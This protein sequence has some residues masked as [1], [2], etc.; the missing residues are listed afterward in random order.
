MP[1]E[2]RVSA[3]AIC[4]DLDHSETIL[5]KKFSP[6]EWK[7]YHKLLAKE[8]RLKSSSMGRLFDAASSVVLDIDKQTYEGEAAMLLEHEAYKYFRKNVPGLRI[9]YLW[10]K[11][12]PENFTKF[13]L[14]K[15][16][17]DKIQGFD[18][19]LLAAKF[20]TTLVDY[21]G[22]IAKQ[23]NI[24]KLAFSGGVFQ[25]AWLADL[26]LLFLNKNHELYFHKEL[27]PNDESVSFGQLIW[28][29]N[30]ID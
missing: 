12:L 16:I 10:E 15:L 2:P 27:S 13:I 26:I 4:K 29:L 24:K 3:L 5:E 28:Y 1:K 8:S 20:H 18:S 22:Q 23:Q 21:I 14:Q 19:E 30:T 9:S 6:T 17:N 25:N 7:I 11:A